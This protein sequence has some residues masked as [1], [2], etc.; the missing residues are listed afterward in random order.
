MNSPENQFDR[1]LR[2]AA[3]ARRKADA[4][5]IKGP[6]AAWLLARIQR[7]DLVSPGV[8][9]VF[10]RGLAAATILLI[11]AGYIATREIREHQGSLMSLAQ[12]A[13]SP[14]AL[15]SVP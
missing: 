2:G 15:D 4:K 1:L 11:A 14:L 3:A 10:Q 8:L 13:Q 12:A 9:L 7:P 5:P 6:N